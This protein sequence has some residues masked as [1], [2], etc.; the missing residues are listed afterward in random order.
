MTSARRATAYGSNLA[1]SENGRE[2]APGA[3]VRSVDE[4]WT[5]L[6]GLWVIVRSGEAA[7]R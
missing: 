1:V 7:Y 4:K 6:K 2:P 5:L 3:H